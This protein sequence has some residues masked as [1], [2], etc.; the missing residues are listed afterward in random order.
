MHADNFSRLLDFLGSDKKKE[1]DD[2]GKPLLRDI[3]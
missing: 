3:P 2:D 1:Y